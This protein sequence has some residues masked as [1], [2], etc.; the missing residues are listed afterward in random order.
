LN[1]YVFITDGKVE[2]RNIKIAHKIA[3]KEKQELEYYISCD[4]VVISSTVSLRQLHLDKVGSKAYLPATV[5][6]IS[7]DDIG[8][9]TL[10]KDKLVT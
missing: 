10:L 3:Y 6:S 5:I 7:K 1:I 9:F 8:L 4:L 2:N